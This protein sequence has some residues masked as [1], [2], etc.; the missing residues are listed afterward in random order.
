MRG[1]SSPRSLARFTVPYWTLLRRLSAPL[2]EFFNIIKTA[3][4]QLVEFVKFLFAWDDI[5][6]TQDVL[7]NVAK[8]YLKHQV[9]GLGEVKA[10]FDGQIVEV[11]KTLSHWAGLDDWSP[12]GD[13]A[14]NPT[15]SSATSPAKDQ[16]SSSML[17]SHH[18]RA[19]VGQVTVRD[20]KATTDIVQ[21]TI[22]GLRNAVS[23]EGHVL[24]E[25]YT[26]L[27]EV[28]TNVASMSV[29]DAIKKIAA[30]LGEGM[31]PSIR[32]VVDALL[33]VLA[34]LANT[35]IDLLDTKI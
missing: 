2:N 15:S 27:Q 10:E 12:L 3:I 18:S 17:F 32:V 21:E 5:R 7:H 26:K 16:T 23:N 6:R 13:V 19:N 9:D 4:E 29:T 28:A 35:A 1:T 30:I 8:L 31:P 33:D 22:D 20:S 34:T 14:S 11:E 25:V 24:S